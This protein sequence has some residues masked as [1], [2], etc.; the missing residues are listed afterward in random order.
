M[1]HLETFIQQRIELMQKKAQRIKDGLVENDDDFINVLRFR[2]SQAYNIP[3][4]DSYFSQRTLDD[5]IFELELLKS[6]GDKTSE[7]SESLKAFAESGEDLFADLS[8]EN[9]QFMQN[10]H[11]FFQTG[12]FI[13]PKD[14]GVTNE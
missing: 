1:I 9:D 12:E 2:L 8:P 13:Q 3:F 6:V 14:K 10:A 11:E 7:V 5:L 4:F